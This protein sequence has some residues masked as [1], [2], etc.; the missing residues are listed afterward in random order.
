MVISSRRTAVSMA[1]TAQC[2]DFL[3]LQDRVFYN[4]GKSFENKLAGRKGD[5]L[6]ENG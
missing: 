6:H 5:G 2:Q 1:A 3:D 4:V